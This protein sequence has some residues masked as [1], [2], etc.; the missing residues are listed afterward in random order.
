MN[1]R[2]TPEDIKQF[3][4]RH[5]LTQ[6]RLG[7]ELGVARCSVSRWERGV[8]SIPSVMPVALR[9]LGYIFSNRR[10]GR[11][12][13]RRIAMVKKQRRE[14]DRKEALASMPEHIRTTIEAQP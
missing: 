2:S 6:A 5:S 11:R 12:A 14:F 9:G 13:K 1:N 10:T 4:E 8:V 3:R 7:K